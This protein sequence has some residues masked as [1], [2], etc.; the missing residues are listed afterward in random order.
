MNYENKLSKTRLIFKDLFRSFK[1]SIIVYLIMAILGAV[2]GVLYCL[3]GETQLSLNEV[4]KF[5]MF[6]GIWCSCFGLAISGI[7]FMKPS[8]MGPLNHQNE[9]RKYYGKFNLIGAI[10]ST[11][12]Y[13]LS[14]SLILDVIMHKV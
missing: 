9:W 13:V 4:V 3:L 1:I 6:T 5:I 2:I 7:A 12:V 8:T 14:Y 11:S 10:L